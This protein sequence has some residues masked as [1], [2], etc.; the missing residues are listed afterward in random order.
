MQNAIFKKNHFLTKN[1]KNIKKNLFLLNI[2]IIKF[3]DC[4]IG[5][6]GMRSLIEY[7]NAII[8]RDLIMVP[9]FR[10]LPKK[11]TALIW[12]LSKTFFDLLGHFS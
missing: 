6:T 10:D 12:S 9:L 7:D 1:D 11:N 3:H 2:F 8:S 4:R 5:F